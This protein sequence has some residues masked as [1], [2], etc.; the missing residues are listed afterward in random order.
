MQERDYNKF[1]G[2]SKV[3]QTHEKKA[4]KKTNMDNTMKKDEQRQ[5]KWVC[6]HECNVG[7]KYVLPQ[8]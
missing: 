8:A 3:F 5:L 1:F 2:F 6:E 4:R 7:E